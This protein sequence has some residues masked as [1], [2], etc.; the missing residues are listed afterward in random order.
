MPTIAACK[1]QAQRHWRKA[2]PQPRDPASPRDTASLVGDSMLLADNENQDQ[3]II[4]F[5]TQSNLLAL[6]R[7]KS[8]YVDGTFSSCPQ[9][10]L[11]TI[12]LQM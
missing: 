9:L 1:E 6:E 10:F 4:V 3:R 8:W 2:D 7:F 12:V 5:G 11:I